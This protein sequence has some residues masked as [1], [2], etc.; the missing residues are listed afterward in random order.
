MKPEWCDGATELVVACWVGFEQA[1]LGV[2]MDINRPDAKDPKRNAAA[3]SV[4]I[5]GTEE[6]VLRAKPFVDALAKGTQLCQC[7]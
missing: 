1:D 6:N 4:T 2:S 7:T 3:V 5:R